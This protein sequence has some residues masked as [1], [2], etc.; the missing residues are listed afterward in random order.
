MKTISNDILS[1][2]VEEHGAE[3][4]SIK[5]GSREYVWQAYPEYWGRHSPVLFP[6]VGALWNEKYY[7]HGETFMMGQHGFARDMDFRLLSESETELWYELTSNE[8]T[9]QKYPWAFNLKIGY[10]LHDNVVDVMWRVRNTG[11]ENMSFQIGAHPAFYYP[12]LSDDTIAEGLAAMEKRLADDKER[13]FLFLKPATDSVKSSVI[14]KNG[15]V[16]AEAEKEITLENGYL[17]LD[18]DSFND[19][20]LIIED[21]QVEAVTLCDQNRTPYLTLQFDAPLVGIWSPPGKNAPFVCIEPWYGRT[22]SVGYND[23]FQDRKWMQTLGLGREFVASYQ[24]I[25]E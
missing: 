17:A 12:L 7:T 11:T 21:G 13:G 16:D 18:T 3:L 10:I 9:L 2:S 23:Y 24:I 19:D 8:K 1:V 20:A 22:D 15:C 25:I 4:V 14:T 6:I 5:K